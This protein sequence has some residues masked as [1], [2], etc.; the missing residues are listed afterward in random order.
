MYETSKAGGTW[1]GSSERGD[2]QPVFK[3]RLSRYREAGSKQRS[4][5]PD[6]S[7]ALTTMSLPVINVDV[8]YDE[9][10]GMCSYDVQEN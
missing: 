4:S 9:E 7:R 10:K 6:A 2:Q 3:L 8:K 5:E 1:C